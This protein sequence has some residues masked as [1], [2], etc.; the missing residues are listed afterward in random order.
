[1]KSL[2]EVVRTSIWPEIETAFNRER[3]LF[4]N[5]PIPAHLRQHNV[6]IK[7]SKT[8]AWQDITG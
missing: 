4:A 3:N 2:I 7:A 6:D 5:F 1:M 8:D